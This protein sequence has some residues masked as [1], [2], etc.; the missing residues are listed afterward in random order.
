M[1]C[2]DP[3]GLD[4]V[5][6]YH[7]TFDKKAT[8]DQSTVTKSAFFQTDQLQGQ[9]RLGLG[10]YIWPTVENAPTDVAPTSQPASTETKS[11]TL[12]NL[13]QMVSNSQKQLEMTL[14][15]KEEANRWAVDTAQGMAMTAVRVAAGSSLCVMGMGCPTDPII[16]EHFTGDVEAD[17]VLQVVPGGST[18]KHLIRTKH[19][20][21][22]NEPY[23]VGKEMAA[24]TL[25]L[26]VLV[27]GMAAGPML[28][29]GAAAPA[30]SVPPTSF[31]QLPA[32][33]ASPLPVTLQLEAPSA[34]RAFGSLGSLGGLSFRE[35]RA[36]LG[37]HGFRL[38]GRSE[39]GYITFRRVISEGSR[40]GGKG[41]SLQ[42]TIR[43]DGQVVRSIRGTGQRFDATGAA[44]SD[45]A[46]GEFLGGNFLGAH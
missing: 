42:V 31:A 3:T 9:R 24:P 27:I 18:F 34:A 4:G 22:N 43:P 2:S 12:V 15:F 38:V 35:A 39:G 40:K 7:N 33:Q 14:G 36:L 17:V 16:P 44:I 45:H 23:R 20:V 8:Y 37:R 30:A 28:E 25:D 6:N 29:A 13:G 19:A 41:T 10:D 11:S 5:V 21:D 26:G 32:S 46:A 1:R